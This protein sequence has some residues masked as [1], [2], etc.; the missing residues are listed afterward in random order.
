MR[1]DLSKIK[2]SKEKYEA[3]L[4][5]ASSFN[6]SIIDIDTTAYLHIHFKYKNE[7]NAQI[8]YKQPIEKVNEPRGLG[9]VIHSMLAPMVKQIDNLTGTKL[10]GCSGC[11]RRQA[12][13]N[14]LIPFNQ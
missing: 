4:A 2:M 9:D 3:Y 5:S 11:A 14:Q 10:S 1:I 12:K 7:V 13:L 8:Q 6:G